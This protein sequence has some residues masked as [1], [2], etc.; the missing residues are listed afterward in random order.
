[1]AAR[2]Q[3]ITMLLRQWR[4]GDRDA[5]DRLASAVY[6]ELHRMAAVYMRRERPGH[7][8]SPTDLVSELFLRLSAAEEPSYA[9]RVQFF[10]TAARQM[11]RLSRL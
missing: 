3:P 8:F 2:D 1:M 9:D 5:L 4:E 11:R 6:E 10:A 7:T